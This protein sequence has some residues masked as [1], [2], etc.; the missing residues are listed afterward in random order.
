M[1]GARKA[2]DAAVLAAAVGIDRAV[3]RDVG[4]IVAGDDLAGG[5]DRDRGLERRQIL[6]ALPAVV[7]ALARQRLHAARPPALRAA[8]AP[9]AGRDLGAGDAAIGAVGKD[10]IARRRRLRRLRRATARS[11]MSRHNGGLPRVQE[12]KKKKNTAATA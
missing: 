7:V 5:I 11:S 2:V 6:E 3:E 9:A 10:G 1:G 12:K 8:A 4:R